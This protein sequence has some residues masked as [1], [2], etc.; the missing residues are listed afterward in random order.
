MCIEFSDPSSLVNISFLCAI[1]LLFF[2]L[3]KS[4]Y[5]IM[6]YMFSLLDYE[7]IGDQV[8]VFIYFSLST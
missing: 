7:F 2:Y 5:H 4:I 3:L 1:I 8:Y 6:S